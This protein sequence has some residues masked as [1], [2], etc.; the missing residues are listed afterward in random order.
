VSER[1]LRMP[2]LGLAAWAGALA[3]LLLPWLLL[4]VPLLAGPGW[5]WGRAVRGAVLTWVLVLCA[6]GAGAVLRAE[7]VE[8]GPVAELAET[9]S[10]V[11]ARVRVVSDPRRL[12]SRHAER[13]LL[14]AVLTRVRAGAEEWSLHT[15]VLVIGGPEW[16]QVPLG[17]TVQASVRLAPSDDSDLAAV[18]TPRSAPATI[19][20]P[21]APWRAAAAVRASVRRAAEVGAMPQRALVPALVDGDDQR[22]PD[23]VQEEFRTTG[24]THL[25]AVS[26]TNLTLVVGFLVVVGRWCGVR[27]RWQYLLGALGIVG[28]L[29]LARTEP[30]VVR[31]AAMGTVA[32]LGLGANGRDRGVRA[33]GAAVLGLLVWDPWLA[34]SVG[35]ALSV[36]ATAGILLLAPLWMAALARWLP[37]WVAA[38]VAV[39]AAA[40][41]ACTPV[42]AAISG[43]VSL[44]AVLA[45]LLAAPFVAPATV[46]GLLGGLFGLVW[47]PLGAAPGRVATWSAAGI[48]T[49]ADRAAALSLPAIGWGTG[50]V[51]LAVLTG[52]CLLL[53]GLLGP[54]LAHRGTGGAALALLLVVVVVPLPRPGWPPEGW[55]LVAC[56]VGQG[57]GLVLRAGPDSAVVV[58]AG[59]DPRPIDRCL[60]RLGVDA[61][62]LVVLSHFHADHVDGL[63]GVLNGREVGAVWTTWL[64]QPA[65]R[66]DEVLREVGARTRVAT[67]GE[68]VVVGDV[69]LQVLGPLPGVTHQ[70]DAGDE[71]SGPNNASVV[72]LAEVRGVRV[73]LTGDIEPVAQALLARSLPGL[74]V[75]VL[76]VPH[77]GSRFQDAAFL[78]SLRAGVAVISAGEDNGHGHP[79]PETVAL[80]RETG[81]EVLRTD[82][83]GDVA[84]VGRA[85]RLE[86]VRSR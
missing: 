7:S 74:R 5:W 8:G 19:S 34:V 49:V 23:E 53:A 48:V 82:T 50:A 68:S 42:I 27:G 36:L 9:R 81:T 10:A 39:P 63:P 76:K 20:G 24:L 47:A 4:A 33:L 57:D 73:L 38:A 56:D 26:G 18:V 28:F 16:E 15:P 80:L 86:V 25:L 12:A 52:L 71:G 3:G 72:L 84:V 22:L 45:N 58:D 66:A 67:Y 83:D 55:L 30:S 32:L 29:L 60:E 21:S 43:Q 79:A 14:R 51:S 44:V 65:T 35:F 37:S 46:L 69:R 54:V 17:S 2:A 6:V 41:L 78:Q 13:W 40:Q 61:V 64:A 11:Q 75:D 70:G 77:H 59:P 62:P 31:A 85:G 1:D